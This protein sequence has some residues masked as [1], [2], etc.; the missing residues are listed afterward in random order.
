MVHVPYITWGSFFYIKHGTLHYLRELPLERH[1]DFR[2]GAQL[3]IWTDLFIILQHSTSDIKWCFH[4]Q[5]KVG[6]GYTCTCSHIANSIWITRT[7]HFSRHIETASKITV[8]QLKA[9]VA[10]M[11]VQCR[12][13]HVI[14]QAPSYM[15]MYVHALYMYVTRSVI[16]HSVRFQVFPDQAKVV[17]YEWSTLVFIRV[18]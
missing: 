9:N 10:N 3:K 16:T 6:L 14:R 7:Q 8:S 5:L 11:H 1:S 12:Y 13:I 17:I 2:L 15:Y 18:W 4:G